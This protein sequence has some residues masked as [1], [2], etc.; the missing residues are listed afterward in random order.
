MVTTRISKCTSA[1]I[2]IT[3]KS[4]ITWISTFVLNATTM[5]ST[6]RKALQLL[7]ISVTVAGATILTF[8]TL[9]ENATAYLCQL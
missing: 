7:R 9:V 8:S 6:L 1:T 2:T 3:C 4:V 5:I